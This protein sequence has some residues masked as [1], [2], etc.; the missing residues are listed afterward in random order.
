MEKFKRVD[1]WVSIFL[2]VSCALFVLLSMD[3]WGSALIVSYFI[4]GG[5]QVLSMTV[6]A[7]TGYFTKRVWGRLLYHWIVVVVIALFPFTMWLLLYIAP[8]MAVFYTAMC[9]H[10][11]FVLMKRPMELLK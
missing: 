8:V 10:E 2:L 7:V 1:C 6:H 3:N 4:V 5:W 9:Y 11:T